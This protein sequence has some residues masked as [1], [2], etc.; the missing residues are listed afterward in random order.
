MIKPPIFSIGLLV[1]LAGAPSSYSQAP[2]QDTAI[3]EGI[4][5][6]AARITLREKLAA[7]R[8]AQARHDLVA[9]AKL[10]DES[11]ALTQQIG[12]GV[13]QELALSRS[14]VTTVRLDLAHA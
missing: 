11:Y 7:A 9:A 14:G 13:D 5:R 2:G 8:E 6:Q 3:Q 12:P 10:Y 1:I 4:R